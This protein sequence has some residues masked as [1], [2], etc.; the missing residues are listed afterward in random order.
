MTTKGVWILTSENNDYDQHGS[1]FRAAFEKKP[2]LKELAEFFADGGS[3]SANVMEAVA[4]LE[5]ILAGGGRRKFEDEWFN[6]DFVSFG[7]EAS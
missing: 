1:Y 5:H 3:S 2:T 7:K 6:L 4:L